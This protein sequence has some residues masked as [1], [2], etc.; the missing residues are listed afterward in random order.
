MYLGPKWGR[1]SP[2]PWV[3][4]WTCPRPRPVR[5]WDNSPFTSIVDEY[6]SRAMASTPIHS[7]AGARI[8]ADTTAP[9]APGDDPGQNGVTALRRRPSPSR[10]HRGR[11]VRVSARSPQHQPAVRS[12]QERSADIVPGERH[13][14]NT[15]T[16]TTSAATVASLFD[17]MTISPGAPRALTSDCHA[18]RLGQ[19]RCFPLQAVVQWP[20]RRL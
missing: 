2:P 12:G 4:L 3:R 19:C 17:P 20:P 6:P 8:T 14:T 5:G 11:T 18:G 16:P 7:P 13:T 9:A 15:H 1:T 10:S